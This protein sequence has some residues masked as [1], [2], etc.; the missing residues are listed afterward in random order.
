MNRPL[1]QVDQQ[2]SV[3]SSVSLGYALDEWMRN[4]ELE[5][6][7]RRAYDGYIGRTIRPALGEEPARKIGARTLERFSD[8]G[9]LTWTVK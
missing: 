3:E 5:D 1:T 9:A 8:S 2:R 4:A 6:S 7:T